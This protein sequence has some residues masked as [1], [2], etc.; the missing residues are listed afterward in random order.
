MKNNLHRRHRGHRGVS[1]VEALVALVVISVG[2]LGIAGLYLSSLQNSR[3]AKLRT[4][5]VTLVGSIADRIRSNRQAVTAYNT[6]AYG[7]AP[8]TQSCDTTQCDAD[9]LAQD[10]LA[11]WIDDIKTTLPGTVATGTVAVTDGAEP[12][13]DNYVVSVTW[14]EANADI[15]YSYVMSL[16]MSNHNR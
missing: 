3:S 10:D 7:G 4:Q 8:A 15:D 5:A 12:T 1:I 13:P 16:D 14:R 9:D 2:M 6:A 11:H